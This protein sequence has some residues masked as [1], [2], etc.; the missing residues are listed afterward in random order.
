ML[1]RT[2]NTGSCGCGYLAC[3][4]FFFSPSLS[5]PFCVFAIFVNLL[6]RGRSHSRTRQMKLMVRG[7]LR[8]NAAR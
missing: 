5:L 2:C 7:R 4:F 3:C 6:S 1:A 8:V